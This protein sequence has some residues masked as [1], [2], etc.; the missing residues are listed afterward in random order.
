M[1]IELIED[2]SKISFNVKNNFDEEEPSENS[3]IGLKNLKDRLN[4][5]YPNCHKLCTS[6]EENIYSTTLEI[7]K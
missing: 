5:L 3:G 2:D 7:V 6:S 1:H 4:L